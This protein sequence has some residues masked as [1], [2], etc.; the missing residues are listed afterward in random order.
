MTR[1]RIIYCIYLLCVIPLSLAVV[2]YAAQWYCRAKWQ[3][4]F[5]VLYNTD[6]ISAGSAIDHTIVHHA[7]N[8]ID[9]HLGGM[10]NAAE[11]ENYVKHYEGKLFKPLKY[12]DGFVYYGD[13]EAANDGI[14]V[15]LGGS[16]TQAPWYPSNWTEHLYNH[17][18]DGGRKALVYNGGVAGYSSNQE[19]IKLIRDGLTLNP[20]VV[21]SYDGI[22]DVGFFYSLPGHPMITPYQAQLMDHLIGMEK[23][24]LLMPN[25]VYAIK[26]TI[27]ERRR[28]AQST[29]N[30]RKLAGINYGPEVKTTPAKQ[31]AR[32]HRIMSAV[33][34]AFGI[35]YFVFLQPTM[36]IG[37]LRFSQAEDKMFRQDAMPSHDGKYLALLKSFYEEAKIECSK[38]DYCIDLT[39][40]FDGRTGLYTDIRHVNE[41]GNKIIAKAIYEAVK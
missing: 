3:I 33:C 35:R 32:N 16:T 38:A 31:W 21:I 26:R 10:W 19:L 11:H 18:R 40:V 17:L 28:T 24:P 29:T 20:S 13:R 4:G 9:P 34:T 14:V 1:Q 27:V 39:G 41:S 8:V 15:A 2:D 25:T 6:Q 30:T 12:A 23:P 22:N 7:H 37:K 36:G 5:P